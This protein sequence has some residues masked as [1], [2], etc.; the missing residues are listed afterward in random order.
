[1]KKYFGT[2]GIRGIPNENL[3]QDLISG[4]AIAVEQILGISSVAVIQDTRSSSKEI[5]DWISK[6]FSEEVNVFNYGVL[7]S[8]SM[9]ILISEFNHDLGIIISASHNPS[10]YNGVKLINKNGSKL[11]DELEIA[12][13]SEIGKSDLPNSSSVVKETE[14]GKKAYE[15]FL[16]DQID[17][18]I[19]NFNLVID[20]AN[21]SAYQVI[22]E[23]FKSNKNIRVINNTPDGENINHECGATYMENMIQNVKKG[24]IGISFDGDAD[25]S[26][27]VDEEGKVSNGD[28]IMLLVSKYLSSKGSLKN[29]V[30][31]STVMSNY[32]FK[33]AVE[34]NNF[35]NI[36]TQVGDKYVA[37]ALLENN[38]S[39]GGE[40]SG[41]II[42]LSN[43]F[44][45]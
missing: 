24:E 22:E 6:G 17:F 3:T 27:L 35:S 42:C 23:L 9:P 38:G 28:V 10:E 1:L 41:H 5:L 21:G 29:N 2:D 7:P 45:K 12:I 43:S 40:Q 33:A 37:E 11:S 34:K 13:E 25:R 31:V 8:G 14:E 19:D 15:Q 4:M 39:L 36:E 30:V 18:N 32:G 44:I 16:L 20:C 26:I